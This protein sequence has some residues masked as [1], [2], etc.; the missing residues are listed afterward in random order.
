[1]FVNL[2]TSVICAM[3]RTYKRLITLPDYTILTEEIEYHMDHNKKFL[4]EDAFWAEESRKWD[5]ILDEHYSNVTGMD[6]RY[7]CIP[8]NI[9]KIVMR[10]KYLYNDKIYKYITY[11][12]NKTVPKD[13]KLTFSLPFSNAFL[14]DNDDKP[15][16]DITEK[17]RRYAGPK[18]NFHGEDVMIKDLLYYDDETLENEYPKIKVT[19]I[20][21]VSKIVNTIDGKVTDLQIS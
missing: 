5:F 18:N 14:L 3:Y 20:I 11:D 12:I 4:I 16:R 15:V 8:Q 13:E 10:T 6:F 19:N 21:G 2:L 17:V 9:D 1:M 7:T